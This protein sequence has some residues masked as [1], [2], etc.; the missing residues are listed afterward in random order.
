M[1]RRTQGVSARALGFAR[2]NR[3]SFYGALVAWQIVLVSLIAFPAVAAS[4]IGLGDPVAGPA[5][6]D[7]VAGRR[8]YLAVPFGGELP[9]YYRKDGY[10]DGSGEAV[11]LGRFFTPKDSGRWWID[12]DRL[13]QKWSQWYE[14][15]V[16][17]FSL[18]RLP[19]NKLI[20]RRD[21]GEEGVA[22]IGP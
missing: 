15:R 9:L 13:C 6:R 21:D 18:E 7:M 14:G 1:I 4:E 17:C 12:G 3:G 10:V 20:W 2:I 8:I 5:M 22:R 11:G 19:E 16:F